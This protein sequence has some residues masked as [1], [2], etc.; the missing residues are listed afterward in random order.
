MSGGSTTIGR[1]CYPYPVA[2]P[3]RYRPGD[4]AALDLRPTSSAAPLDPVR[5]S[6][7]TAPDSC[8]A[9]DTAVPDRSRTE[10]AVAPHHCFTTTPKPWCPLPL[11]VVVTYPTV[12]AVFEHVVTPVRPIVKTL[13]RFQNRLRPFNFHHHAR[14]HGTAYLPEFLD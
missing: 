11:R 6:N 12:V 8:R 4:S 14:F 5:A 9:D 2:A 10:K 7:A 3:D 13:P 1:G